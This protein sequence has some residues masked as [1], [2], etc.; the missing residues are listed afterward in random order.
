MRDKGFITRSRPPR[1][2]TITGS[3]NTQ[4]QSEVDIRILEDSCD[5]DG[6]FRTLIEKDSEPTAPEAAHLVARVEKFFAQTAAEM[7]TAPFRVSEVLGGGHFTSKSWEA[8][9]KTLFGQCIS[10]LA[11][12][13]L[14]T[15]LFSESRSRGSI[16]SASRICNCRGIFARMA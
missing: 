13:E 6:T 8:Q 15:L 5:L 9:R 7:E 14:V 11:A 16:Q 3:S 10:R 2:T 12:I 4:G 1:R